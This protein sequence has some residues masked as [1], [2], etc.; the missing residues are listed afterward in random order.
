[1]P[2]RSSKV[3]LQPTSEFKGSREESRLL[4]YKSKGTIMNH[5]PK[6]IP[7]N[8]KREYD[9]YVQ[10][11]KRYRKL[12]PVAYSILSKYIGIQDGKEKGK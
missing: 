3:F 2:T 4:S 1:M 7:E 9:K 11:P 10:D 6:G 8:L 12:Y 5:Y